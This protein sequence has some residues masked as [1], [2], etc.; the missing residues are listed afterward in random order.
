M[1]WTAEASIA[2]PGSS[3]TY[4]VGVAAQTGVKKL[5]GAYDVGSKESL[6]LQAVFT[7][8][9]RAEFFRESHPNKTMVI[10][11]DK[12]EAFPEWHIVD[13]GCDLAERGYMSYEV[14]LK[15]DGECIG[16]EATWPLTYARKSQLN[17]EIKNRR[18]E[19][20]KLFL[21][22]KDD[23]EALRVANTIRVAL[24]M[25]EL[26]DK[27]EPVTIYPY[28][29]VNTIEYHKH[30]LEERVNTVLWPRIT[31]QSSFSKTVP[32]QIS[33]SNGT[34]PPLPTS[35]NLL[36]VS[37]FTSITNS[38]SSPSIGTLVQ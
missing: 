37:G 31:P 36:A 18:A 16:L 27:L 33:S 35:S 4:S 22:G 32:V 11:R 5:F 20:R 8:M 9:K 28:P 38:H 23:D 29:E 13:L 24:L 6:N 17:Y 3:D 15:P 1:G 26:W 25:T 19:H 2:G 10:H 12:P 34:N 7:T 30:D 14:E 21:W